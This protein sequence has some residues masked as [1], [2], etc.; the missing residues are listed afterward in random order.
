MDLSILGKLK[1]IPWLKS[2]TIWVA[3]AF[4]V[5]VVIMSALVVVLQMIPGEAAAG[6]LLTLMAIQSQ[7]MKY[8][9]VITK[10]GILPVT[11]YKKSQVQAAEKDAE[12][13]LVAAANVDPTPA[14]MV[15][16]TGV[17]PKSAVTEWTE[18]EPEK[19]IDAALLAARMVPFTITENEYF[20]HFPPNKP[21][22]SNNAK[23]L[24]EKI[25]SLLAYMIT[26]FPAIELV[27]NPKTGTMIS[28]VTKGG[29][30]KSDES[31]GATFSSHKEGM[32]I[33]I[34]DPHGYLDNNITD[35]ILEMFD[36]YREHPQHTAGWLHAQTRRPGS[37]VRT[38]TI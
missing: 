21:E 7:I 38:Y 14:G 22:H 17:F 29:N 19:P 31:E 34:T 12:R 37:G 33:D 27:V 16:M 32:G 6:I 13:V 5:V 9:R 2:R 36:L 4:D 35:E 18:K 24:I 15:A 23:V 1:D 26:R 3:I 20:K 28:G 10:T 8:M 11:A 25:N 30:R